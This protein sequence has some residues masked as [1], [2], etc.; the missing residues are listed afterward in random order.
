MKIQL[1]T[2]N[3]DHSDGNGEKQCY[4]RHLLTVID[5]RSMFYYLNDPDALTSPAN[6]SR[7]LCNYL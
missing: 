1:S 5:G 2:D 6:F 4:Q 3:T 7:K